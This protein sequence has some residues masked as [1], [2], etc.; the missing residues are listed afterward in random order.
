MKLA[1]RIFSIL[2]TLIAIA[3]FIGFLGGKNWCFFAAIIVALISRLFYKES[4]K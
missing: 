2:F 3:E 1:N 4:K